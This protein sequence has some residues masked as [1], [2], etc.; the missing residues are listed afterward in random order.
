MTQGI[1]A[2]R[3][4]FFRIPLKVLLSHKYKV[5]WNP[6]PTILPGKSQNR[7]SVELRS[8]SAVEVCGIKLDESNCVVGSV[9]YDNFNGMLRRVGMKSRNKLV[10]MLPHC[11]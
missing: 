7:L 9:A 6:Q 4:N 8:T 2:F 10:C 3:D 11:K 1:V 5:Y